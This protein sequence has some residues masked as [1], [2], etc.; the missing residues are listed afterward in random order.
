MV[1]SILILNGSDDNLITKSKKVKIYLKIGILVGLIGLAF[2]P[3]TA[4]T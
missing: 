4:I 1:Y 3:F 2:N